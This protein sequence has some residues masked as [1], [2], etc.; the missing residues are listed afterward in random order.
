MNT[1]AILKLATYFV[2]FLVTVIFF[3]FLVILGRRAGNAGELATKKIDSLYQ[4]RGEMSKQKKELSKMGVMYRAGNYNL[5]PSWYVMVRLSVGVI[6]AFV[7][8]ILTSEFV[9]S[10]L[11]VPIGYFATNLYFRRKNSSDNKDMMMDFYNTFASLKLQMNAGVYIGNSLEYIHK[12]AKNIRFK[13]ALGELII[14]F[15]D[16]TVPMNEAIQIFQNRFD[17]KQ[18]DKLCAL[19]NNCVQYGVSDAY[20]KDIMQETETIMLTQTMAEEHDTETKTGM[21]TFAFFGVIIFI[22]GYAV[23]TSFSGTELF[24]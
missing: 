11:F 4:E 19:L 22:V 16:K 5:S 8:Y 12:N 14:N 6:I 20:A 3:I 7:I 21:I 9:L 18:I 13:E 2:M 17:C 10:L 15:S 1:L 24:F 23:F